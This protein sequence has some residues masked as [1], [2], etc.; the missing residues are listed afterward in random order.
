MKG[1]SNKKSDLQKNKNEDIP[2]TQDTNESDQKNEDIELTV[3]EQLELSIKK[4]EENWDKYLRTAAELDNVR[5]R[6]SRDIENARKFALENFSRELLNIVDTLE[7]AIDSKEPDLDTL[8]SGNKATLQLMQNILEQFD[9]SVIDPHGEPFNAEF[10]EAMSMQPSDK[11][12][13]GSIMTVFQKGYL[14]NDRLLRPARVVV[15]SD[16]KE[17]S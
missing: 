13:P 5:K 11:V 10:H 17:D 6:A 8:L 7:M 1:K 16:I 14:L 3:E 2:E 9:I 4:S 12:E 15:A